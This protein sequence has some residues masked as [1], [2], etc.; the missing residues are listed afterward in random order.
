MT[1]PMRSF[2]GRLSSVFLVLL[3]LLSLAYTYIAFRGALRLIDEVEFKLNSSYA[4]R[5]ASE[6]SPLI[7]NGLVISRIQQS[8]HYMM[9]MNP[10]VEIY[11]LDSTGKVVAFFADSPD[12]LKRQ[13]VDLGPIKRYLSGKPG[14]FVEGDD[15][16]SP[17]RPRPF[18]VARLDFGNGEQGYV[19]V[20]LGGE[21]FET[22]LSML[23]DSYLIRTGAIAVVLI[24]FVTGIGG[25]LLFALL[26]RRLRTLTTAVEA[27]EHG[28]LAQR[29]RGG[30]ADEL[31]RLGTTFNQ[32][33]ETIAA[34]IDRMKQIDKLR[35]DLVANVSHDLRSPLAS[36]RGY[37]ETILMHDDTL[38]PE[39]RRS[40][41]D[42]TLRNTRTLERLVQE[43]FDL[44]Q[45]ENAEYRPNFEQV[46][47]PELVQDVVL[48]LTP[49]AD[50]R[51]VELRMEMPRNVPLV[52]ADIA[53]IERVVTNL[54]ENAIRYTPARGGVT[55]EIVRHGDRVHVTVS[56]NG[57]GIDR[58]DLPHVFDRF[59]RA[60]RSRV[61]ATD[62]SGTGSGLGLAIA[63][64]IIELHGSEVTVWSELN[65][66]SRF[67][68]DLFCDNEGSANPA[69]A[70]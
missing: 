40:Y 17:D 42:I 52:R 31:D 59:Y 64:R 32:M 29:V 10:R 28:D 14:R 48:K 45:L 9:V 62:Q 3:M 57:C 13:Q 4:S 20:I 60:D 26:T 66:G 7:A 50:R 1:N 58:E 34:D 19:Y 18:S 27:F 22:A 70:G 51:Q 61:R 15:P 49:N 47:M 43:L 38:S 24:L 8:I 37:V 23:E 2:Y 11:L 33:A 35:R 16:R 6:L 41:L 68:F 25:L 46:S 5:I 39:E 54:I 69:A 44:S 36:I 55:V 67:S 21:K 63:K 65:V 12:P 30:S 53:L 56:D